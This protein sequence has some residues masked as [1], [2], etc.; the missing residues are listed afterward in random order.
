[1]ASPDEIRHRHGLRSLSR[2]EAALDRHRLR[3][4]TPI[5]TS[6]TETSGS[7]AT[8]ATRLVRQ[9]ASDRDLDHCASARPR[10]RLG[11]ATAFQPHATGHKGCQPNRQQSPPPRIRERDPAPRRPIGD[12]ARNRLEVRPAH[13]TGDLRPCS[14]R[15]GLLPVWT[16]RKRRGSG[17]VANICVWP[18]TAESKAARNSASRRRSASARQR[19]VRLL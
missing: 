9:V 10:E 15:T 16:G 7:A 19:V 5:D 14:S 11:I 13:R 1:M 3:P 2:C 18:V 12:L 17:A 6:R 8:S 4:R